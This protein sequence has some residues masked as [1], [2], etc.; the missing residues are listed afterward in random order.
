[1][2]IRDWSSDVCSSDLLRHDL[3]GRAASGIHR[4]DHW[5]ASRHLDLRRDECADPA[6]P[7]AVSCR[8]AHQSG[9][10]TSEERRVGIEC[11]SPC[12]S[13]WSPYHSI[14]ILTYLL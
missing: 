5:Q 2:R 6:G 4:P 12:R 9:S 11:V 1:M 14:N 10:E 8:H 13:R 7:P 3:D